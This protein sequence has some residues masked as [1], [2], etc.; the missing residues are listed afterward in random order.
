MTPKTFAGLAIVTVVIAG[1]A[2][3]GVFDRYGSA[4]ARMT[5]S[6]MFPDL[7]KQINTVS[8]LSV[9]S[10][11]RT[12]VVKRTDTGWKVAT[13]HD[14][15]AVDATVREA[16][17]G[18]SRLTLVDP[19]TKMPERFARLEV[20]DVAAKDAKSRLWQLKDA[21]GKVMAEAL[22][23][24]RRYDLGGNETNGLYVRK[25]GV[26]Q[27][28]L[29]RAK[30]PDDKEAL[31][32]VDRKI[33]DIRKRRI[34]RVTT[35][36]AG[37]ATLVALREDPDADDYA[38]ENLPE[39]FK[40]KDRWQWDVNGMGLT[41]TGMQFDAVSP[42]ADLKKDFAAPPVEKAVIETHD[43]LILRIAMLK[44][45]DD[46]SAPWWVTIAA[47]V[48]PNVKATPSG[49]G[50]DRIGTPEDVQKEA[51]AINAKTTGWAYQLAEN[52]MKSLRVRLADVKAPASG[53]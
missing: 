41:L 4:S 19:K 43:G 30:L 6:L 35:V 9:Q 3:Y 15:P 17:V 22:M 39:G 27:S 51:K 46:S 44:G 40:L 7:A 36:D 37:G 21:S 29:A 50:A 26:Q 52:Q 53:S 13:N 5:E 34:E 49:E 47:D 45:S 11:D 10:A 14:Y 1:A 23:G 31:A 38:V 8:E 25:P 42:L 33:V 32:F 28:W 20:E 18:L 16:I 2:T 24:R 12:V 48:D